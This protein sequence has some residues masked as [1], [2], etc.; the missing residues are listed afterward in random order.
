VSEFDFEAAMAAKV[1]PDEGQV[2][3]EVEEP[4]AEAEAG[5]EEEVVEETAEERQRDEK[6]RFVPKQADLPPDIQEYLDAHGGDVG[7]ALKDAIEA[8]KVIGRQGSELGDLR[9]QFEAFESAQ[10]KPRYDPN[11]LSQLIENDPAQA[12]VLAYQ[13]GDTATASAALTAWKEED[14]FAASQWVTDRRITELQNNF[15]QRLQTVSAPLQQRA[16]GQDFQEALTTFARQN[17][18][19]DQYVGTMQTIASESP[20][21]LK[22]LAEDPSVEAKIEVYDFLYNKARVRDTGRLAEQEQVVAAEESA[23]AEADKIGAAVASATS[24]VAAGGKSNENIAK[25]KALML[26]PPLYQAS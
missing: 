6:G 14:P 16:A 17:P 21:I 2:A 13:A 3:E 26:E 7:A 12:T 10:A 1:T 9:K 4:V 24:T 20:R 22:I 23:A 25:F 5:E 18:D 11:S 19:L 15:D 8:Q